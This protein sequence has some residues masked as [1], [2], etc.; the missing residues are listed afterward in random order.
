LQ[1]TERANRRRGTQGSV[2][3]APQL[4]AGVRQLTAFQDSHPPTRYPRGSRECQVT[5]PDGHVLR[6]GADVRPGE[7]MGTWL[8]GAGQCWSP[9]PDGSWRV[10]S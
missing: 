4:N 2:G 7:P 8:D 5:D 10:S 3:P 9:Q 1:L 6:I